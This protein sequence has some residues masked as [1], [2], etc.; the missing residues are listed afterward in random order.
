MINVYHIFIDRRVKILIDK[1]THLEVYIFGQQYLPS[2][3]TSIGYKQ[4]LV[5][6]VYR[7]LR[8]VFFYQTLRIK[9]Y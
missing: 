9:K 8:I 4:P 5:T 1:Y 2:L 7:I 3:C 6:C